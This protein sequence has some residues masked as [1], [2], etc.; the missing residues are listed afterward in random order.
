M[1]SKPILERFFWNHDVVYMYISPPNGSAC[2]KMNFVKGKVLILLFLIIPPDLINKF[3][4]YIDTS[5]L[6]ENIPLV[7]FIKS[8]SG[9]R[10]AY[11]P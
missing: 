6:K 2:N 7:T 9:T 1:R 11:F 3:L 8:A 10:V 4:Y 5:V